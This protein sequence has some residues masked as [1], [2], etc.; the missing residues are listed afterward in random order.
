MGE[1]Y[2]FL[3]LIAKG[4]NNV[5]N[6]LLLDHSLGEKDILRCKLEEMLSLVGQ[7]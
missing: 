6:F 3:G 4:G 7:G 5:S 1:I 2:D